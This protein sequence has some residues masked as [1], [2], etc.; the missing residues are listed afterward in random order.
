[1][2]IKI[3][4][5]IPTDTSNI[6]NNEAKKKDNKKESYNFKLQN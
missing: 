2:C 1:M 4:F 5:Y 6:T 3:L